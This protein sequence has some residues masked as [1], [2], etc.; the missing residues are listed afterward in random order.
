MYRKIVIERD[1]IRSKPTHINHVIDGN[2]KFSTKDE[3]VVADA[4]RSLTVSA[5]QGKGITVNGLSEIKSSADLDAM[6][7]VDKVFYR[8]PLIEFRVSDV[9]YCLLGEPVD[10]EVFVA[11]QVKSSKV[12]ENGCLHFKHA[13]SRIKVS[14]M[15][16]ILENKS[17]LTCI[18]KN[19]DDIPDV[20]WFFN[21]S[22]AIDTL[23]K[24][25]E[26]RTFHPRLH[27][28]CTSPCDFT[29][30]M[31][32]AQF[33]YDVGMSDVEKKRL[34]QR[35]LEAVKSGKKHTIRYLNEHE[36]Q[37]EAHS[38]RI[39]NQ[40]FQMIRE[41]CTKYDVAIERMS[42][43]AY[44]QV[45][46]RLDKKVKI[47]DKVGKVF[48]GVCIRHMG[49]YPLN[50]DNVDVLQVTDLENR[51]CYVI[52]MRRLQEGNVVSH[53]TGDQLMR[54]SLHLSKK[55][56]GTVL[57]FDLEVDED[58]R[59]YIETCRAKL[60]MYLLSPIK[61]STT[62]FCKVIPK[63]LDLGTSFTIRAQPKPLKS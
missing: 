51:V 59:M 48:Q 10:D 21:G 12:D 13:G 44:S 4:Q 28:K 6:I 35:K 37:I 1:G 22:E 52:P 58:V 57:R 61:A 20:I 3:K 62:T 18:G 33:R 46:F 2:S 34:L 24:F 25:P 16:K 40:S 56:L 55:W 30:A 63:S 7:G 26:E 9:T 11:D 41:L 38:H 54:H 8:V 15:I 47:Q 42:D 50:P 31:N 32:N 36:S 60:T 49:S 29:A 23:R 39:E 45:D 17:T 19:I 53:F 14:T 5:K 27:L 43:D